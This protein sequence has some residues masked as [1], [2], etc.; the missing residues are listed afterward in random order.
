MDGGNVREKRAT[1]ISN[2]R[3]KRRQGARQKLVS[4]GL[5]NILLIIYTVY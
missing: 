3:V 4:Q 2:T 1:P 5:S